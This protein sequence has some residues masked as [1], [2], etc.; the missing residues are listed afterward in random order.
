[1]FYHA[2]Y[3]CFLSTHMLSSKWRPFQTNII[4]YSN[5]SGKMLK[6]LEKNQGKVREFCQEE[7]VE[8]MKNVSIIYGTV[9]Y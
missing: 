4:Y 8:T 9:Y 7:N 3:V 6:I 1:M 5:V 2:L